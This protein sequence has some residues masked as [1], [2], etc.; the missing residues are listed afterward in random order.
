MAFTS[1]YRSYENLSPVSTLLTSASQNGGAMVGMA[2][3]QKI[4]LSMATKFNFSAS[5]PNAAGGLQAGH[6]AADRIHEFA[7]DARQML[8]GA[9]EQAKD[10]GQTGPAANPGRGGSFLGSTV[11][12]AAII[13]GAT[14]L[15]GPLGGAMAGLAVTLNDIMSGPPGHLGEMSFA[16]PGQGGKSEFNSPISRSSKG[17]NY[18]DTQGQTWSWE[19]NPVAPAQKAA[20][21]PAQPQPKL[22]RD[23]MVA[24]QLVQAE[25]VEKLEK[26]LSGTAKFEREAGNLESAMKNY[27]DQNGLDK[28]PSANDPKWRR[29]VGAPSGPGM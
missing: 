25:G 16:I 11:A 26:Q 9:I 23:Q 2:S 14:A 8:S 28:G 4:N 22:T 5:N 3:A 15:A 13:G 17:E 19:G 21:G 12:G 24:Q 10:S 7:A 18:K 6:Q 1:A 27:V 29:A 20:S